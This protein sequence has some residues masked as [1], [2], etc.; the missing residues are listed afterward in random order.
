MLQNKYIDI[1]RQKGFIQGIS[2]C[3]E[4][5]EAMVASLEDAHRNNRSICV[6]WIDLANAYGSPRHNMIQFTLEWYHFPNR[7]QEMIFNYYESLFACVLLPDGQTEW[8]H[9]AIGIFQGCTL[10]TILFDT[11]FN[12]L[13]DY[14]SEDL[15]QMGYKFAEA[16][17]RIGSTGYADD[18]SFLTGLPE[19]NQY[20]LKK[21]A[22]WLKATDTMEEKAKKCFALARKKFQKD[23]SQSFQNISY[24]SYDPKLTI[25]GAPI[26]FIGHDP[27][28]FLGVKIYHDMKQDKIREAIKAKFT[29]MFEVVDK[30]K[31]TG[32]MKIWIYEFF[33]S[34]KMSWDLMM[35]DT[36]VSFNKELDVIVNRYLKKWSGLAKPA[37][38]SIFF[39]SKRHFG[40][41]LK[42]ISDFSKKLQVIK[43]HLLKYSRDPIIRKLYE[44]RHRREQTVKYW[45]PTVELESV[46]RALEL[47]KMTDGGQTNKQGL[48][49]QRRP[50]PIT[51]KEKRAAVV[52]FMEGQMEEERFRDNTRLEMQ[53]EWTKW[54]HL[55]AHDL[56]WQK[57]LY[58]Q[59]GHL[60][61]FLLNATTDTCA[62]QN[63]LRRW[64]ATS[65]GKCILCSTREGTLY[66]VL[67]GCSVALYENSGVGRLTW[68]HDSILLEIYRFVRSWINEQMAH[69]KRSE[70]KEAA[71]I[72]PS[73]PSP[74]VSHA[75]TAIITDPVQP[76]TKGRQEAMAFLAK[77]FHKAGQQPPKHGHDPKSA[78]SV[79]AGYL[80]WKVQF[81]LDYDYTGKKART[82]MPPEI[83]VTTLCPD[84]VIWSKQA[85]VVILLEL[86][87]PWEENI[88]KA[89]SRKNAKY[90]ELVNMCTGWDVHYFSVEV[91]T[92]GYIPP[93][94]YEPFKALGLPI[95]R[96]KNLRRRCADKALLCS[97]VI[98]LERNNPNWR[99]RPPMDF[100]SK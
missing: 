89:H 15:D 84:G 52:E 40:L 28:K 95:A 74:V 12:T 27:F 90:A 8:F 23:P 57:I 61:K 5:S 46:E 13:F 24:S 37:N 39:R 70:K 9:Q 72:P 35:Y 91:G 92:R 26:K 63:N 60:F 64:G 79:F 50:K 86:T 41:H 81:D 68:R 56:N 97:Y 3:L 48:G 10:S 69:T 73:T 87:A 1:K 88:E 49:F 51:I 11:V 21:T 76:T 93:S 29:N 96:Q 7:I 77:H 44:L 19:Q 65:L 16:D 55:M 78:K 59:G 42:K 2:G 22:K 25:N 33:I 100:V 43:V 20:L 85:K 34:S 98:Y 71:D 45:T 4:F 14:L 75:Q 31:I 80:D 32:P 66:H 18:A 62:T 53:G 30:D 67:S 17:I 54:K 94:F 6:S 83:V 47:N 99:P 38:V 82:R 36:P 58:K